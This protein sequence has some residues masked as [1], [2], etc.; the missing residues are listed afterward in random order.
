MLQSNYLL[1]QR[2]LVYRL[3]L[4]HFF[5]TTVDIFVKLSKLNKSGLFRT[6]DLFWIKQV[7]KDPK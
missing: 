6:V 2:G 4:R 1:Y 3:K 5:L 7:F